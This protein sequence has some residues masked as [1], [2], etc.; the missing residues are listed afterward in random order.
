MWGYFDRLPIPSLTQRQTSAVFWLSGSGSATTRS[1]S[2]TPEVT[3]LVERLQLRAVFIL[4][5]VDSV[6][7][8]LHVYAFCVYVHKSD[9]AHVHIWA[10][11]VEFQTREFP[12]E[13]LMQRGDFEAAGIFESSM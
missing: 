12:V 11:A 8:A 6:S 2:L 5:V 3:A 13:L 9:C 7:A 10:P 4:C 1:S